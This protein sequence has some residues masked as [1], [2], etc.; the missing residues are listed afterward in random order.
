MHIWKKRTVSDLTPVP[1]KTVQGCIFCN[2]IPRVVLYQN[3]GAIAFDVIEQIFPDLLAAFGAKVSVVDAD[4]DSRGESLVEC[5]DYSKLK[6][7]L[8]L[9]RI[10]LTLACCKEENSIVA[11]SCV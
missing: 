2:V 4:M 3:F 10:G 5:S 6:G 11:V 7:S 1:F 9:D 8:Q